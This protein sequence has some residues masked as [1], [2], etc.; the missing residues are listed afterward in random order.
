MA[1]QPLS[2]VPA[3][4]RPR[5]T[6]QRLLPGDTAGLPRSRLPPLFASLLAGSRRRGANT[7]TRL[8][9]LLSFPRPV[10]AVGL[11]TRTAVSVDTTDIP[12]GALPCLRRQCGR[13]ISPVRPSWSPNGQITKRTTV[14]LGTE[15]VPPAER[16]PG[17]LAK[18]EEEASGENEEGPFQS[19]YEAA[20][21]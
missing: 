4:Y 9:H 8:E 21:N 18:H 15:G 20:P 7:N 11:P 6:N 3:A 10:G 19:V 16:L 1:L 12:P 5:G 13:D 17:P 2:L 14:E